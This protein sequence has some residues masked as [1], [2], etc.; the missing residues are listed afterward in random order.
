MNQKIALFI[1]TL[2]LIGY[3]VYG[4]LFPST[5]DDVELV[6]LYDRTDTLEAVPDAKR[7]KEYFN[8]KEDKWK[9]VHCSFLPI[10]NIRLNKE[11]RI[12]LEVESKWLS[13]ELER[14]TKIKEFY[15]GIDAA[16]TQMENIPIGT[17][18]SA[19][20]TPLARRL[21]ALRDA[22]AMNVEMYVFSDLMEHTG[23]V[24]FYDPRTLKLMQS[25][26]DQVMSQLESL[27]P[28][29]SLSGITVHLF[30]LPKDTIEDEQFE[31]VSKFYKTML[32]NHNADVLI[33]EN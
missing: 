31:I 12:D 16:I 6:I 14:N 28:L 19:I 30:F 25:N 20:Y 9:G 3:A 5:F 13:N 23:E 32:G 26:P 18:Q 10:T 8:L 1:T 27:C 17:A 2:V 33:N 21:N 7:I 22:D 11:V 24:S 15:A 29:K 4:Q